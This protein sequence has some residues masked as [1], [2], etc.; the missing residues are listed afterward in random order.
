MAVENYLLLCVVFAAH[1]LGIE[2]RKVRVGRGGG[3]GGIVIAF[4]FIGSIIAIVIL[5]CICRLFKFCRSKWPNFKQRIFRLCCRGENQQAGND[6]VDLTVLDLIILMEQAR[7][8]AYLRA[9]QNNEQSAAV[10]Q[11]GPCEQIGSSQLKLDTLSP[12]MLL[13]TDDSKETT[14]T[15]DIQRPWEHV[16]SSQLKLDTLSPMTLD[17]TD[18]LK[19]TIAT[20]AIQ[21]RSWEQVGT[22][23][24]K[25]DTLSIL[26]LND[27]SITQKTPMTTYDG[28][29]AQIR[30]T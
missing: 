21:S 25:L 8:V 10:G 4:I 2:T 14:A 9:Q 7:L 13:D 12:M 28:S 17:D 3:G 18:D 16:G 6:A 30:H 22:P 15:S 5:T 1:I 11:I 29:S 26:K 20:S 27:V 24:L 23:Q 19:E